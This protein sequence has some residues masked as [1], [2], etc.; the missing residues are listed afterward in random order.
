MGGGG[1]AQHAKNVTENNR[2]LLRS[3]RRSKKTK[4]DVYGREV[5]TKLD[6]K[7]SSPA[8]VLKVRKQMAA[9]NRQLRFKGFLAGLIVFVLLVLAAYYISIQT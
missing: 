8:D 9:Y 5:K 2:A 4:K 1:F 7:K 3:K 6:L